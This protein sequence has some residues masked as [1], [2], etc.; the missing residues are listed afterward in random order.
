M[1][2]RLTHNTQTAWVVTFG[3]GGG[4][5]ATWVYLA[6]EA[7]IGH[8]YPTGHTINLCGQIAVLLLSTFG[9]LYCKWENKQRA[10]G[11]RDHRLN[12][13]SE[14]EIQDLGYRHPEF[15]YMH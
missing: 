5:L 10:L 12:G 3:T 2:K 6:K 4:V 8:G 1:D 9:I 13:K 14:R 15:R 11:K 7:K